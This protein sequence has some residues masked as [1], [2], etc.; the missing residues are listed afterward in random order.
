V[1]NGGDG[2]SPTA[3][4]QGLAA[5]TLATVLRAHEARMPTEGFLTHAERI[6]RHP[7]S[8]LRTRLA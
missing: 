3:E 2:Y 1:K 4:E 7:Q 8:L 5:M 6:S